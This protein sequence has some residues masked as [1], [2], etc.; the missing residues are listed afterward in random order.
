MGGGFMSDLKLINL[1]GIALAGVVAL[2][3]RAII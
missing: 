1:I 2:F 3:I